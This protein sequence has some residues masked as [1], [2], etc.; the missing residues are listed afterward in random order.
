MNRKHY[1]FNKILLEQIIIESF[2]KN[3]VKKFKLIFKKCLGNDDFATDYL[4]NIDTKVT[5]TESF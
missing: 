1:L 2:P 4:I 3:I 5:K